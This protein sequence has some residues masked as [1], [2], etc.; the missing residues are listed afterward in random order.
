[1]SAGAGGAIRGYLGGAKGYLSEVRGYLGGVKGHLGCRAGWI[2]V[3]GS[4]SWN[5]AA[6]S[7][8]CQWPSD[9]CREMQVKV[10]GP[11]LP[12]GEMACP[13]A[14]CI[15]QLLPHWCISQNPAVAQESSPTCCWY[16]VMNATIPAP[17]L[18]LLIGLLCQRTVW[19]LEGV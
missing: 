6:R 8:L 2:W 4:S 16:H 15:L 13:S 19:Q 3:P 18:Q 11:Q 10:D 5:C 14:H 9:R 7:W 12:S 1:M 17:I